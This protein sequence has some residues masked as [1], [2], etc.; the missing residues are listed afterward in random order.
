MRYQVST[1]CD[2]ADAPVFIYSNSKEP[3]LYNQAK[4]TH[5]RKH[6]LFLLILIGEVAD[7][8]TKDNPDYEHREV[9]FRTSKRLK[10]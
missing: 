7:K 3:Q 8:I 6:P 4:K 1:I 5:S 9:Y 10:L 2:T